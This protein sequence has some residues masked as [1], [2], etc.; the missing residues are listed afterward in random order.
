M[1]HDLRIGIVY[2][3]LKVLYSICNFLADGLG[4]RSWIP[5]TR[6]LG[7][8]LSTVGQAGKK[9]GGA[10]RSTVRINES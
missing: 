7:Y 9:N 5:F 6:F 4:L 1:I 8:G 10:V 2:M 3:K